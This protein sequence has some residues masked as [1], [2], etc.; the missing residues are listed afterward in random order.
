MG[1]DVAGFGPL[2]LCRCE[3]QTGL[4]VE[5]SNGVDSCPSFSAISPLLVRAW[6][7]A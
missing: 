2:P 3:L 6:Q 1:F 5:S 4:T 7:K